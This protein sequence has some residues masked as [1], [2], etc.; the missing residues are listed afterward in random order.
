[1]IVF[2]GLKFLKKKLKTE[3]FKN[4]NL[5]SLLTTSYILGT[6]FALSLEWI[7]ENS[8]LINF[9]IFLII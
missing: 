8:R 7:F 2:L 6:L 1:V 9:A 3:P 4:K 5:F